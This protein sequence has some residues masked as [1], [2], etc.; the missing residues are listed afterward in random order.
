LEEVLRDGVGLERMAVGATF[1]DGLKEAFFFVGGGSRSTGTQPGQQVTGR[2]VYGVEECFIASIPEC[3][4]EVIESS[5]AADFEF[6]VLGVDHGEGAAAVGIEFERVRREAESPGLSVVTGGGE[7]GG[8]D[9][10]KKEGGV[11]LARGHGEIMT[12]DSFPR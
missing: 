9:S 5:A 1:A 11:E 8:S 3:E 2:G 7:A 12:E 6:A 4:T 10:V